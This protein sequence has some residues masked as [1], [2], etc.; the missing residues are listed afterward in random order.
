MC[1]PCA[2]Q[3]MMSLEIS[4]R[5]SPTLM[6]TSATDQ[7][8]MIAPLRRRAAAVS[9]LAPVVRSQ[10]SKRVGGARSGMSETSAGARVTAARVTANTPT[11]PYVARSRITPIRTVAITRKPSAVVTP[12]KTTGPAT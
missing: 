7:S 3:G 10:P 1:V 6:A 2:N 9:Q 11:A 4:T 5:A 8:A 12:E